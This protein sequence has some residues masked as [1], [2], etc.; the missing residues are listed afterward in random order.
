MLLNTV[1]RD[2]VRDG[3]KTDKLPTAVIQQKMFGI[4]NLV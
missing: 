2:I 1:K 3:S 4:S